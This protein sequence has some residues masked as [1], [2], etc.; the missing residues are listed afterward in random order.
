M[1]VGHEIQSG[2]GHGGL[3]MRWGGGV[4]WVMNYTGW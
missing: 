3:G 1:G 4:A 2:V